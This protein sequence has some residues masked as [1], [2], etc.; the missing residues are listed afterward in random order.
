MASVETCVEP[1][2]R[3]RVRTRAF[4]ASELKEGFTAEEPGTAG[5]ADVPVR[6]AEPG[7]GPVAVVVVVVAG[8]VAVGATFADAGVGKVGV[9]AV[10]AVFG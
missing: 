1:L 5:V 7:S 6:A 3:A 8:V 2:E 10:V 4:A 9:L